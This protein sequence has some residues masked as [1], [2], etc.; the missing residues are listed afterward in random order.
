M[1]CYQS[2]NQPVGTKFCIAVLWISRDT[3]STRVLRKNTTS[4]TT[5]TMT[6]QD[7]VMQGGGDNLKLT[8][9][10][11]TIDPSVVQSH[12][13]Q[14]ASIQ[15]DNDD[16][17]VDQP[18]FPEMSAVQA[19]G[20]KVEYRRVRCPNHRYTPLREHWEQIL[21]PLVEYLKLQVSLD[22]RHAI[23]RQMPRQR[24][25]TFPTFQCIRVVLGHNPIYP[26]SLE[27]ERRDGAVQ[28]RSLML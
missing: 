12:I 16:M 24:T 20:G 14:S 2:A 18:H 22:I 15:T 4:L 1:S 5:H 3:N 6:T 17:A 27:C 23:I 7:A 8:S 25:K 10:S 19:S 13:L 11:M 21:T 28:C 9:Q 26:G